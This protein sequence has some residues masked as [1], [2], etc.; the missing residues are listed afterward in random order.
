MKI[1]F[2]D[3]KDEV[4]GLDRYNGGWVKSVTGIDKTKNNGYSIVGNFTR[5]AGDNYTINGL[6]LDCNIVGS[7]KNQR[8]EYTLFRVLE[9][10]CEVLQKTKTINWAIDLWENIEKALE[11][12]INPLANFSTEDLLAEINRR[13]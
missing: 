9:I 8:K 2:F 5:D 3:H 10:G 12:K 13:N 6:Y 1:R 7:R 11:I 4:V